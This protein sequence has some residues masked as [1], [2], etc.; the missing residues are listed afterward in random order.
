MKNI[1]KASVAL[2]VCLSLIL[3]SCKKDEVLIEGCTD[4]AAMIINP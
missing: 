1:F 2:F 4:E 3:S